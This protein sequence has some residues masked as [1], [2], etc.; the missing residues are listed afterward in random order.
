MPYGSIASRIDEARAR[1]KFWD[2]SAIIPLVADE[3]MRGFRG[4]FRID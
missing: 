2:A 4:I 1:V 3:P